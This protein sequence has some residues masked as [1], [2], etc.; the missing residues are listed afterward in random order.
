MIDTSSLWLPILLSAV[1]VFVVSSI[2]HMATPW[3]KG[4]LRATPNETKVM[5]ALRPFASPPG[6]YMMPR[7]ES[8]SE[9]KSPEFTRK[10]Q[11]GPVMIFTVRPNGDTGMGKALLQWFVYS[12]VIS[13]MA[14]YV[15][16]NTLA[17]GASYLQVFRFASVVAFLGY[18]GA[19]WQF[20]IW[21]GRSWTT[22]IKGTIDGAI[23]AAVTGGTLGWLWPHT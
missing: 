4:D 2:I 8:M 12:L 1:F 23:Y 6:D 20:S 13:F 18:A 14:A 15:C 7:C 3:H 17:P 22:T 16:A 11:Q 5:D 21:W 10:L 9:M 19:L